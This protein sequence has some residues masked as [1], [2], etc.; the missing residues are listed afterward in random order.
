MIF[1]VNLAP[2]IIPVLIIIV[3]LTHLSRTCVRAFVFEFSSQS[4]FHS[5]I[6]FRVV[7]IFVSDTS[8]E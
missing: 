8:D 2:F 1:P 5:S 6:D 4:S 3:L 7:M